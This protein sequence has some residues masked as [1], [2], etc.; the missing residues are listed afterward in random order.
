MENI[1]STATSFVLRRYK[2]IGVKKFK[3]LAGQ[4]V[5]KNFTLSV[6]PGQKIALVGATGSGKTTVVN[7]LMRFYDVDSGEILLD[8]VNI[9]DIPKDD[10]RNTIAIVLQDTVLFKDT[11]ANSSKLALPTIGIRLSNNF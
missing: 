3:H 11:I 10:L 1:E 2:E 6:K 4:K 7:L 5:L 9:N 8:G